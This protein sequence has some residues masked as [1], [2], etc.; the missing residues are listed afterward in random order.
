MYT[1][2]VFTPLYNLLVYLVSIIPGG[3]VGIAVIVLT[4]LLRIVMWP[5]AQKASHTQKVMRE[6]QPQ[7]DAI[8]KQ[9]ANDSLAQMQ[10]MQVLYKGAGISPFASLG[11][12]I[13]QIPVLLG[14]Y[15][16]VM[17][18][19]LAVPDPAYIY[20]FIQA[21][22]VVGQYFLGFVDMYGKSIELAI[23]AG[24]TQYMMASV[25]PAPAAS[26]ERN[27]ANDFARNMQVQ[28]KYVFPFLI[29]LVSYTT[30]AAIALYFVISN[31]ASA[32]QEVYNREIIKNKE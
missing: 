27:F 25:M 24:V 10:K 3:D 31:L 18:G 23:L 29:A 5:L 28:M 22:T 12:L 15:Q 7:F 6:L 11:L 16:V 1:T 30:S 9:Y 20:S 2:L 4:I 32:A 19:R 13:I 21:P 17:H 26:E 14:L 8:K